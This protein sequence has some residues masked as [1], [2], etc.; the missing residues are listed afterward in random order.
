ML[1]EIET[2]TPHTQQIFH[3]TVKLVSVVQLPVFSA[4]SRSPH[5]SGDITNF[6]NN[7]AIFDIVPDFAWNVAK[8]NI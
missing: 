4:K 1:Q 2:Y 6:A 3:G 8:C 5:F 7:I